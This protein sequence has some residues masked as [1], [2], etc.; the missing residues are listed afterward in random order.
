MEEEKLTDDKNNDPNQEPVY[1]SQQERV[2]TFKK[3]LDEM[4]FVFPYTKR[5]N[6]SNTEFFCF[7]GK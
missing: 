2:E 7:F 6:S 3:L 5:E 4:V 1:H